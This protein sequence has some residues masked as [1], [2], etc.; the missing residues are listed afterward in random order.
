MK[1]LATKSPYLFLLV[2]AAVVSFTHSGITAAFHHFATSSS[3]ATN[4]IAL[5]EE[6]TIEPEPE[7]EPDVPIVTPDYAFA[8]NLI[9]K[10]INPGYKD[11]DG[12]SDSGELV[13]L[14]KTTD[15]DLDLSGYS[16]RYTNGSGTVTTIWEFAEGTIMHGKSLVLRYAKAPD[17]AF[18]DA[19]YTTSLA[20][21][22]GPLELLLDGDVVDQVC[23]TG[24]TTCEKSFK[25]T[26][27]TTLV[28]NLG[29]GEPEHL[30]AYSPNYDATG[31]AVTWPTKPDNPT[32]DETSETLSARCQGLEFTEIYSYYDSDVTEQFI[33]LYNSTSQSIDVTYCSLSYKNK[34]YQITGV[35]P[36]ESYGVFYPAELGFSLTKNPSTSNEVSLVDADGKVI[37]ELSY[38]HGQK[39]STSYSLVYDQGG[40]AGWLTTYART[41]GAE[42]IYQKFRTCEVGKVI[43]EATGNCVKATTAEETASDC[44]EGKYRNPLTNRCKTIETNSE[45]KPCAEGYERNPETNRCRKIVAENNGANY[46][47]I[48]ATSTSGKT[49]IALGIVG[50]LVTAGASYIVWQF[51]YEIIRLVRKLRQRFYHVS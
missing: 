15:G 36:S 14:F 49:F 51:R 1:R 34:T 8:V 22:A 29:T 13:E 41:P 12:R 48:P 40:E 46:A 50:L 23:W 26:A 11:A 4:L 6:P 39:K 43:N 44:P 2:A 45:P 20:L 21:S 24:K 18:S 5:Q 37:D 42:N 33:E 19:T 3:R 16:L 7:P 47:L 31:S 30:T 25:S 9:I 35:I 27:P 38:V 10:A 28:R 32:N 17:S